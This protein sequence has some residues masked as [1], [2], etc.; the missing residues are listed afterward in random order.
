MAN[1]FAR[2]FLNKL[3]REAGRSQTK[4]S[5]SVELP[6]L[7]T[8]DA[9]QD[10]LFHERQSNAQ[11]GLELCM[12]M[13]AAYD[14]EKLRE[15]IKKKAKN[16]DPGEVTVKHK[17]KQVSLRSALAEFVNSSLNESVPVAILSTNKHEVAALR[18]CRALDV[19]RKFDHQVEGVGGLEHVCDACTLTLETNARKH[20]NLL[21]TTTRL[22]EVIAEV[23]SE[24]D[25][26]PIRTI[27]FVLSCILRQCVRALHEYRASHRVR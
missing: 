10:I 9:L 15:A 5:F 27:C 17:L 2:I 23:Q 4:K 13:Y 12:L 21:L 1:K 14:C 3:F 8:C 7:S 25:A 26:S 19:F 18:I 20:V 6:A 16:S 24:R 22:I 11:D